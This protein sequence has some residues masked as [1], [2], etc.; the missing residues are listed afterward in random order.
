MW[1]LRNTRPALAT[2]YAFVNPILAVLAGAVL[3]GEPL[4]WTTLVAN[5]M[6]VGAV[7]LVLLRPQRAH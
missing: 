4:G 1:L 7:M 3:H 2:S 6:I 5:V